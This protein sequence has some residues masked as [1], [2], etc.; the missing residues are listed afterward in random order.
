MY[1]RAWD[2][3]GYIVF[4]LH[5]GCW[6]VNYYWAVALMH[7]PCMQMVLIGQSVVCCIIR[8]SGWREEVSHCWQRLASK[9]IH[10]SH[11]HVR[12]SI[13]CLCSIDVVISHWSGAQLIRLGVLTVVGTKAVKTRSIC[14]NWGGTMVW[15]GF[16]LTT[17]FSPELNLCGEFFFFFLPW[18]RLVHQ[19]AIHGRIYSEAGEASVT[20]VTINWP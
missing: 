2:G 7:M 8:L 14:S 3:A 15:V 11:P 10:G 6:N 18:L 5:V 12:M 9:F 20:I 17:F 16:F 1:Y 13:I 19:C 4:V